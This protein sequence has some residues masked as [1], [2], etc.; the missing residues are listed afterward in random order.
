[1]YNVPEFEDIRNMKK[2]L[3]QYGISIRENPNQLLINAKDI[4][5]Q[6]AD[7]DIAV[8]M[9]G[10]AN[11]TVGAATTADPIH[12]RGAITS[13]ASGIFTVNTDSVKAP[14]SLVGDN[15]AF[16]GTLNI[17]AGTAGNEVEISGNFQG[18]VTQAGSTSAL[19]ALCRKTDP[20]SVRRIQCLRKG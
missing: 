17:A 19:W 4:T 8:N 13:D 15:T 6:V 10:V 14:V 11:F 9:T 5:N 3:M 12:I 18:N 1:M 20:W 2:I 16:Q 7:Y